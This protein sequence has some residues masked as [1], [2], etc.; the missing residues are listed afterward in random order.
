MMLKVYNDITL[1]VMPETVVK[2]A[3]ILTLKLYQ[4]RLY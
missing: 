4:L 1:I 2:G 3:V